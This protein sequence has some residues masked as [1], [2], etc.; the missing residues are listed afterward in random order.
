MMNNNNVLDSPT[1]NL[2]GKRLLPTAQMEAFT[3]QPAA[4]PD[5]TTL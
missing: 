3:G 5:W 2:L 4:T 1:L